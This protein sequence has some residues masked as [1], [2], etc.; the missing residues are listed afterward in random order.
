M[1]ATGHA[2][3]GTVIAATIPNPFIAAPL[4]IFSHLLVDLLPHW[5][6]GTNEHKKPRKRIMH[7]AMIDV[8]LGFIVS[9]LLIIFVFPQTNLFYAFV[10]IIL[11][12][13]FDWG[14]AP[15]YFFH[16]NIPPFSTIFH[17]CDRYFNTKQDK[18]WGIINQVVL[19]VLLIVIAK[20]YFY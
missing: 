7:E 8:V 19:L 6:V 17:F 14:W 5:D 4:A 16:L 12:Q 1:T 3:I 18:P 2:V 10:M 15:Y 9:Y 11:S 20:Y 13:A